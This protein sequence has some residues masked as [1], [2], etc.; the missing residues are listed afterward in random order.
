M[1]LKASIVWL[2]LVVLAVLN[3]IAR[4]ALISP[5][6]GE[7]TGH[8]VSTI[9]LCGVILVLAW[10]TN[11]WIAPGG[12]RA[13]WRV[14]FLWLVLTVAFEFLAGHYLFGHSW[15]RLFADYNLSRGRVWIFVLLVTLVA[16]AAAQR[17]RGSS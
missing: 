10:L 11:P 9:I 12:M 17:M 6:V 8:V 15:Q 13:A 7:Q 5:H 2:G 1:V 14:G 16:P 4:N 3:G